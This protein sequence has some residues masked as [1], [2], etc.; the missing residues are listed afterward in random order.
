ME[1]L[2]FT[3]KLSQTNVKRKPAKKYQLDFENFIKFGYW[4]KGKRHELN[5]FDKIVYRI[6]NTLKFLHLN[7]S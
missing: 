5:N 6:F 7:F 4:E 1:V 3:Q 2:L